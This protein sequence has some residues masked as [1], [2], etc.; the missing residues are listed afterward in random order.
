M[1]GLETVGLPAIFGM[2]FSCYIHAGITKLFTICTG[3]AMV[4]IPYIT[5]GVY[6]CGWCRASDRPCEV[7]WLALFDGYSSAC[8]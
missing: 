3:G 4:L 2:F 8:R 6:T 5:A 7:V 1:L